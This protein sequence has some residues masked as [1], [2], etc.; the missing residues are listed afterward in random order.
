[1]RICGMVQL[2][3]ILVGVLVGGWAGARIMKVL[4]LPGVL[5][6]LLFGVAAGPLLR[7]RAPEV[8]WEIAPLLRSTALII[9]LL[10]AG[11][12]LRREALK[13]SG[14]TALLLSVLPCLFEGTVLTLLFSRF[15]G[16][17]LYTAGA[18]GFLLSAVSP[19]VVV[20]SMLTLMESGYGRE[21]EVP[22]TILAA[23]SADDVIA[24]SVFTIFLNL[25]LEQQHPG[26]ASS[27]AAA[28][29]WSIPAALI[30]AIALGAA[31][32]F[33]LAASFRRH[34]TRIRATEK[35]MLIL[36]AAVMFVEIGN[37]LHLAALLGIMTIGFVLV[38]RAETVA[39]ELA[40]K[41]DKAWVIAE[42]LLFVLIGAAVDPTHTLSVGLKG[43]AAVA[44]GLAARALGVMAALVPSKFSRKERLFCLIAYIPKATVQAAL[45]S[46]ALSAGL[47]GGEEILSL[48]V[49]AILLTAPLG[50]LGIRIFGP[51]LL[52][53]PAET[54]PGSQL[55][56]ED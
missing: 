43:A 22:T 28:G 56:S 6:M 27:T 10:R 8:F 11:L 48:A 26:T 52:G 42:I 21:R 25:A 30:G 16:F 17:D 45:G 51:R 46:A 14:L 15:W 13:K 41:L 9:I 32:G 3:I 23:A 40:G 36:A 20:P 7:G 47:P 38:E 33:I 12:G 19:A 49:I 1:V 24:V 34:H 55:I 18:A 44:V 2:N 35:F 39:H 5:G 54:V 31:A 29:L 50:L 4:R 37:Y 53:I